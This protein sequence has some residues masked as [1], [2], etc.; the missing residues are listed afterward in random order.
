MILASYAVDD[1]H[2]RCPV[3]QH[4]EVVISALTRVPGD[5]H[6]GHHVEDAQ[7]AALERVFQNLSEV[8]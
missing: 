5:D 8:A 2:D 6:I 4:F 3:F 1:K 7:V